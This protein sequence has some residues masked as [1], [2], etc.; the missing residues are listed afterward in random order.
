MVIMKKYQYI[1]LAVVAAVLLVSCEKVSPIGILV[2]GT[3]V[4]DRLN[5]SY[6]SFR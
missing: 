4:E 3:G 2:A 5:M 1:I 6:K